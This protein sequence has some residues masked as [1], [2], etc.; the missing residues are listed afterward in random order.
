[1]KQLITPTIR[2]AREVAATQV[3]DLLVAEILCPAENNLIL[4]NFPEEGC[5]IICVKLA[6]SPEINNNI[7]RRHHKLNLGGL[8]EDTNIYD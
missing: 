6:L 4:N 2:P 3:C 8:V 7:T 1:M 5:Y